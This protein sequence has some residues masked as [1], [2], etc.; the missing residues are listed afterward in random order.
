MRWSYLLPR[1]FV[2]AVFVLF[3]LFGFDPAARLGVEQTGQLS[4]S[5]PVEIGTLRTRLWPPRLVVTDVAV[6]EDDR[7]DQSEF[8]VG[9]ITASLQPSAVKQRRLVVDELLVEDVRWNVPATYDPLTGSEADD[10]S[11]ESVWAAEMTRRATEAVESMVGESA[12]RVR[13]Q[14]DPDHLE[15]VRLSRTKRSE[16]EIIAASLRGQLDTLQKR[17][18]ELKAESELIRQ[19]P[20]DFLNPTEIERLVTALADL[21]ERTRQVRLELTAVR[22]RLPTD[23]AELRAAKDRDVASARATV[24]AIRAEPQ[25]MAEALLGEPV[26]RAV[27]LIADWAPRLIRLK[28]SGDLDE[29]AVLRHRGREIDFLNLPP[30]PSLA[31]QKCLV[32]GTAVRDG[33][34]WPFQLELGDMVAAPKSLRQPI[35]FRWANGGPTQIQAVGTLAVDGRQTSLEAHYHIIDS[36]PTDASGGDEHRWM[37]AASS[38]VIDG[39]IHLSGEELSGSMSL[40]LADF[41]GGV[42]SDRASLAP[43]LATLAVDRPTLET[44]IEFSVDPQTRKPTCSIDCAGLKTVASDLRGRSEELKAAALAAAKLEAST[45]AEAHIA[46]FAD[47]CGERLG[48]VDTDAASLVATVQELRTLVREPSAAAIRQVVANRL[49]LPP[50]ADELVQ[51]TLFESVVEAPRDG[52][53]RGKVGGLIREAAANETVRT[54]ALEAVPEGK[55]DKLVGK[56]R[57]AVADVVPAEIRDSLGGLLPIATPTLQPPTGLMPTGA[58]PTRPRRTTTPESD[59]PNSTTPRPSLRRLFGR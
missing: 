59:R 24:A 13:E 47:D 31:I 36:T 35:A 43:L 57:D 8:E 26:G 46:D 1:G 37:V 51:S 2:V 30:T 52:L 53:T 15:T 34:E 49:E 11:G 12:D 10:D 54:A 21:R 42:E 19:T 33:A 16:Y 45:L 3:G 28:S 40:Q 7:I 18:R 5:R 22:K 41:T 14:L 39:S 25:R 17:S 23:I 48:L 55:R 58:F 50:L 32:S 9:T 6:A 20:E 27:G 44:Q 38:R 29:V 56:A 4:L